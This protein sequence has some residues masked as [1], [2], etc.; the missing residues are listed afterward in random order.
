MKM[1]F[2]LE[3]KNKVGNAIYEYFGDALLEQKP[4]YVPTEQDLMYVFQIVNKYVFDA[5]LK[6]NFELRIVTGPKYTSK[7]YFGFV[8]K[9]NGQVVC[10]K[11]P[12]IAINSEK[13]DTILN[14]IS[15]FCH[16]LIH[17]YDYQCGEVSK[18]LKAG[19]TPQQILDTYESH[20][21]LFDKF[22]DKFADFAI[23]ISIK[24]YRGMKYY[25][26]KDELTEA[27]NEM[28]SGTK[29]FKV[30]GNNN[31]PEEIWQ[32]KTFFDSIKTDDFF[33]VELDDGIMYV[34]MS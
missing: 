32:A 15:V 34:V 17:L 20:K 14:V 33:S 19:K 30:T 5:E 13:S 2:L 18:M 28:H 25:M 11:T 9:V 8:E 29:H 16:E 4:G 24:F 23:P 3:A 10:R 22:V 12:F 6:M 7:G 21:G 1:K 26:T 31:S 27:T